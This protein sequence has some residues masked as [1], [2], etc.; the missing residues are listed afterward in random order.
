MRVNAARLGSGDCPSRHSVL[1]GEGGYC[2]H[3]WRR[4]MRSGAA[5]ERRSR[6][7]FT[8]LEVIVA[9]GVFAIGMVAVIALFAPVASSVK[10]SADIEAALALAA[11]L[12]AELKRRAIVDG[13]LDQIAGLLKK[14]AASGGHEIVEAD[15]N[16]NAASAD[17][18]TDVQL[19]FASRDGARIGGYRDPVWGNTDEEKFFE[20][21]F[22]RNESLAA[23]DLAAEPRVMLPYIARIRWPAFVPDPSPTN[24]RRALPA[25]FNPNSTVRFD[26]S[27]KRVLF[28][29]GSVS[30]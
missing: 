28:L 3:H 27:V 6:G 13:G 10:D 24:P 21:A 2:R 5:R 30:R 9:V 18:R 23:T 14:P 15:A 12:R 7:A 25:G 26:H 29:A 1:C 16:P 17:P 8:L 4:P 20:I 19:L 22:I 11:P